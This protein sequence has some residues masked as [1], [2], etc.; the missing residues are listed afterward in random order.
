[1]RLEAWDF[2]VLIIALFSLFAV[3]P[4]NQIVRISAFS[5][6]YIRPLFSYPVK[7]SIIF[8]VFPEFFTDDDNNENQSG[9]RDLLIGSGGL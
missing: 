6:L 7:S 9:G 3:E 8:Q 2:K 4:E 1:M 5:P